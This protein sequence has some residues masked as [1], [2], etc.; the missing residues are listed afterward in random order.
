MS[1]CLSSD[2]ALRFFYKHG[3]HMVNE[4]G[5]TMSKSIANEDQRSVERIA[6]HHYCLKSLEVG[7]LPSPSTPLNIH[8]RLQPS[9]VAT[10]FSMLEMQMPARF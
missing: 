7:F 4:R 1:C 10:A 2:F 3:K 9:F 5:E 6:L 8:T